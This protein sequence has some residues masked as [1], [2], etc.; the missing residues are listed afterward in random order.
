MYRI[1]REM[2]IYSPFLLYNLYILFG[3]NNTVYA[4]DLFKRF[5]RIILGDDKYCKQ[6][7]L[8]IFI[9][10]QAFLISTKTVP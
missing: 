9:D 3:H 4:L 8:P 1:N 7:K 10:K 2:I 6:V 5:R